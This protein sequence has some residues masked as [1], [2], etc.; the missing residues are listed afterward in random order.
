ME[1]IGGNI[2]ADN[3]T[4]AGPSVRNDKYGSCDRLSIR[5][6]LYI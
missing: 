5:T 6:H 3:E 2:P 1:W 4:R